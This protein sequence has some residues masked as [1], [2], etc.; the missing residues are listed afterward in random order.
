MK[1]LHTI[2]PAIPKR[3]EETARGLQMN[4]S[5]IKVRMMGATL[6]YNLDGIWTTASVMVIEDYSYRGRQSDRPVK[7]S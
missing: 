1:T 4:F 5:Q 6:Q 3:M 2:T 7:W